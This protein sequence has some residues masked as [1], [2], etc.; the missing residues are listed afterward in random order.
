MSGNRQAA[1]IGTLTL[2][3][4]MV[5][6]PLSGAAHENHQH[7]APVIADKPAALKKERLRLPETRVVDQNGRQLSFQRDLVK[8]RV[9]VVS[10]IY[11]SCTAICSPLTA[12]LQ[13]ARKLLDPALAEQA[14]F[15]SI[16]V[17]PETDTPATLRTFAD[18]YGITGNWTFVTGKTTALL[19]IQKAFAVAMKRKED[20]TPLILIGN[21]TTNLWTRKY[22][23]AQPAA[24]A[25]AIAE[26]ASDE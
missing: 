4:A 17:E 3:L 23:L 26:A 12:N 18:Q 2:A 21:G 8:N 14:S 11:T 1:G 24:I 7:A 6:A 20:H 25:A 16:S 5:L 22:G 15:I 9:V 13:H 10:F 19:E